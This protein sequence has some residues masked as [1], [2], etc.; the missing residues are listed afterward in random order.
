MRAVI[1]PATLPLESVPTDATAS[2]IEKANAQPE[3]QKRSLKLHST[4]PRRA[5]S[6]IYSALLHTVILVILGLIAVKE[7]S[8]F[9]STV[10]VSGGQIETELENNPFE[11]SEVRTKEPD[12]QSESISVAAL[13]TNIAESSAEPMP[14]TSAESYVATTLGVASKAVTSDIYQKMLSA[15]AP[16]PA[17]FANGSLEGRS[18]ENRTMLALSRGG[19]LNSEKAVEAA[20][21]WLAK[22]QYRDGGWSTSFVDPNCPCQGQC[23]HGSTEQLDLKR[24]AATG[25]ALLSFLGA[26]YTHQEGKYKDEVYRGLMFL[27]DH[28]KNDNPDRIDPR[29]PGQFTSTLSKHEMYEQGI[30]TLA[31]CEA[32]QMTHD[33]ILKNTCQR[34][35]D[36]ISQAQHYDGSWGY[37]PKTP[38]DLSIVGWQ[39]M[40]IKSANSS[41]LT[42]NPH[43]IQKIDSFLNTQQSDGGARYGY[44]GTAPTR[45]MT[46]IGL[47]MRLYRGNPKTDPRMFRGAAYVADG[48]PSRTDFYLNY[49]A[50]QLL[51][52]L[53]GQPW[54]NWNARLREHL[55]Q[56]QNQIGHEAGSW[57]FD[58]EERPP[59]NSIGGRLYCTTL[60]AMT[61]EV[62]YRYMPI[63]L[64]VR[65][66]PFNF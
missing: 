10:N 15:F 7:R 9:Q 14:T 18:Q 46:S 5:S 34:A 11:I 38:G 27:M 16:V 22:H 45:S 43:R 57:Y 42:I 26:G 23:T 58:D 49:Y 62:Y 55:I 8:E 50:S 41:D 48:G 13:S 64:D 54:Q 12:S 6:L 40:S 36:F 31:I 24:P 63:Y 56:S 3:N 21:V 65:E 47:L 33:P 1:Q 39:M 60:A 51:F 44:R 35:V 29:F 66:Q 52:Q 25:L 28:I 2:P 4:I 32:F 37:H 59:S 61:L 17:T 19:S 20:L 53:G 30:A